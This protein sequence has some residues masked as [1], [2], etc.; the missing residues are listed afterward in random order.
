[1]S[2]NQFNISKKG[3]RARV[4]VIMQLEALECGAAALAMIMAYYDKWVP[5]EQVRHDCGVSRDG[6]NARNMLKAARNYGFDAQGIRCE[7]DALRSDI[8]LPCI[9]H[10]NFNHFVVLTG[11][12]GK[13]AYINDPARGDL[14]ITYE[15]L[16][17][18]FTGICI[19]ITPGPDFEPSGEQKSV[20]EFAGSRLKGTRTA[21]IFVMLTSLTGALFG[22]INPAFSR[23]FMDR[24]LT[25]EN[26]ELLY[27]F[28][29]LML[30][31]GVVQVT[32]G[33]ALSV[34]SLRINGKMSVVG[35]SEY[36]W[37]VLR[38]PMDFFSQRLLGD[39]LQRQGTNSSIATT[40]VNTIAPLAVNTLMMI[41]Y[42]VIMLRWSVILT[43]IGISAII[44]NLLVSQV[45][46]AKRI[47]ITRIQQRDA[48]KLAAATISGIQMIETIKASGSENGYFQKWAG[49]QAS[50]NAQSVR[51]ARL[52]RYLGA[53]PS[54]L[55][56]VANAIV[57]SLG[58]LL[59]MQGRFSLGSIL[60]FQGFL[61]SFM[62]RK[63]ALIWSV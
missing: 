58:V 60:M 30:L 57:L 48:G 32:A 18:A 61:N 9:I 22:I 7:T 50:V 62:S 54:A 25:G 16:D 11:F 19:Q 53:I 10:W 49:Y 23:F 13:Y 34:Y 37:K 1:M 59:T 2:E 24:L 63:C 15:E 27:P 12:R 14:R 39:I 36:M 45:I 44:L 33:W 46:S 29:G 55:S 35:S 56:T 20:L 8:V 41:V 17:N 5:L 4:P 40:L 51:Y 31:T 21:L 6:S 28:L 38:L 52:N 42:L 43:M 3:H 26:T 47:N